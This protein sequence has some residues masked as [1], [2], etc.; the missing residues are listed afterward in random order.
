[1]VSKRNWQ[2]RSRSSTACRTHAVEARLS[3]TSNA[4][5]R[6]SAR[7]DHRVYDITESVVASVRREADRIVDCIEKRLED[8][9]DR[10]PSSRSWHRAS[11]TSGAT[12]S[13][14]NCGF[15]TIA[16]IRAPDRS[17]RDLLLYHRA[18][19]HAAGLIT[20]AGLSVHASDSGPGTA[21]SSHRIISARCTSP[22]GGR[23]PRT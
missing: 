9:G 14:S 5:S 23:T 1:M 20:L 18:F 21:G 13:R 19:G 15:V 17:C 22:P 16:L 3:R 2:K 8:G 12:W 6:S 10:R 11:T 7:S 4:S